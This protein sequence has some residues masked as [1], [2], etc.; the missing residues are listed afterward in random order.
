MTHL[1]CC[2]DLNTWENKKV[3]MDNL[4]EKLVEAR[5]H[6]DLVTLI[7]LAV[8]GKTKVLKETPIQN[9][10]D[11]TNLMRQQANIGWHMVIYGLL[12]T[13]WARVQTKWT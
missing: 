3:A 10:E 12:T 6:P 4:E 11:M 9:G 13:E 5:T 2:K 7:L 8:D 1:F